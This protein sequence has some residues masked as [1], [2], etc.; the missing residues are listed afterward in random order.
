VAINEL[1][2]GANIGAQAIGVVATLAFSF[3]GTLAILKVVDLLVGIRV[4]EEEEVTGLD[5]SQHAEMGYTFGDRGGQPVQPVVIPGT[6]P[7]DAA[8]PSREE[9]R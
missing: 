2:A 4:T 7:E 9:A 1:S 3:L 5:L 8:M 6:P